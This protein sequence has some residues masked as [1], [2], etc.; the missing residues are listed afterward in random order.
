MLKLLGCFDDRFLFFRLVTA[1]L[2]SIVV[3][4]R[5]MPGLSKGVIRYMVAMAVADTMVCVFN[6]TLGN[7]FLYHFPRSFHAHTTTCR[8]RTVMQR[9]SVQFSVWSTVSFTIDRFIAICCQKLKTKYCTERN[10]AVILTV[11][12]LLSFLMHIFAYFSYE[13]QYT[14]GDVQWGCRT[15]TGYNSSPAWQTYRWLTKLM[16][17]LVPLPLML[18]L[19]TLTARHILLVS[20]ARRALK[21]CGVGEVPDPE[22][23]NRRSSIIL[24]F[25]ISGTFIALWTPVTIIDL[26]FPLTSTFAVGAPKSLYLAIRITILLM[27]FSCCT[28]TCVYA[29]TQR[30]FREGVK[31]LKAIP[32][33]CYCPKDDRW[34]AGQCKQWSQTFNVA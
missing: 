33:Q 15:V 4:S 5:E 16:L 13:P 20:R 2:L 12:F 34:I 29:L 27:Y 19:N 18:L 30:R 7:V 24:L 6:V 9:T 22:M 17:P 21:R 32:K 8:L 26:L 1:N 23:T 31:K 28:N 11:V 3:L 10:P 25:A 14:V